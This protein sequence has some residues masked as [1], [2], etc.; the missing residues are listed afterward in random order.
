[1]FGHESSGAFRYDAKILEDSIRKVLRDSGETENTL[2]YDSRDDSCRTFVVAKRHLIHNSPAVLFKSYELDGT[3]IQCSVIQAARAT[4]A[5]PTYFPPA[6][7]EGDLYADGGIGFNNPAGEAVREAR[8]IW[9][10]RE[11][12]C[13]VSIG[14]GLMEP[15]SG[16]SRTT[17]QFG[18]FMGTIVKG[19]AS[20]L[21][22]KLTVAAYCTELATD[23]QEVHMELV[24]HPLLKRLTQ[25]S[26]YYRFNVTSGMSHIG[27]QESK[28]LNEI[29]QM[30]DAYLH[31][32]ERREVITDCVELLE[33]EDALRGAVG[34]YHK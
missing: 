27:I 18:S 34:F 10:H 28:K 13:L 15:I 24:E 20:S 9:P 23:C 25:R 21:A 14:T 31:D 6:E 12:G 11:I 5:A 8:R 16:A 2:L 30:T 32:P 3:E 7:I 1:M 26:R 17:E 19:V 4:S 22:E 29:S 33:S